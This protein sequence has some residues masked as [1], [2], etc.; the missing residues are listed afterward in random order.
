MP[1]KKQKIE[2]VKSCRFNSIVD[3][4]YE[5]T[6]IWKKYEDE[7]GFWSRLPQV[8]LL[9]V[10]TFL[11][12]AMTS[13]QAQWQHLLCAFVHHIV[14][15]FWIKASFAPEDQVMAELEVRT[16]KYR[17]VE[18][19]SLASFSVDFTRT[20]QQFTI[21]FQKKDGSFDDHG[22]IELTS[23]FHDFFREAPSCLLSWQLY[24][25]T[26]GY[27]ASYFGGVVQDGF[28]VDGF[29]NFFDA[30]RDFALRND[31]RELDENYFY[32]AALLWR[33]FRNDMDNRRWTQ[34]L[35]RECSKRTCFSLSGDSTGHAFVHAN[36][37]HIVEKVYWNYLFQVRTVECILAVNGH[38]IL[39]RRFDGEYIML[40]VRAFFLENLVTM[41]KDHMKVG[42]N[43]RPK[44]I[45]DMYPNR[46]VPQ[47]GLVLNLKHFIKPFQKT[48]FGSPRILHS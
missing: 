44:L 46:R 7:V 22:S 6:K 34:I 38:S 43:L 17:V 12:I 42:M 5:H 11:G 48:F 15:P 14:M 36:S 4:F 27:N 25:Y 9:E 39:C 45:Y 13:H 31:P 30:F 18:D 2:I 29:Y 1:P 20:N 21:L 19:R 10:A 32:E 47:S 40:P 35:H 41:F 3:D 24:A 8:I 28:Y 23:D 37:D 26:Y 33:R 16:K